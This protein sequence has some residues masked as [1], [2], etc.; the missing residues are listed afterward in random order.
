VLYMGVSLCAT[1]AAPHPSH[2]TTFS[3][4]LFSSISCS[5]HH[6]GASPSSRSLLHISL[7]LLSTCSFGSLP[8]CSVVFPS[9]LLRSALSACVSVS[10]WHIH[11]PTSLSCHVRVLVSFTVWWV[12][13]LLFITSL[14]QSSY[15]WCP[16]PPNGSVI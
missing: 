6:L 11:F 1:A 16:W 12:S 15:R 2:Y 14:L 8:V 7:P 9:L 13:S 4:T 10:Y 5:H 3:L